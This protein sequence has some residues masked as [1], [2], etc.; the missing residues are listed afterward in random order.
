MPPNTQGIAALVALNIVEGCAL[1]EMGHNSP[2]YLHSLIEAM[3]VAL[4]DVRNHVAD[5]QEDI[6]LEDLLS[7]QRAENLRRQIAATARGYAA[8]I[9]DRDHTDTVYVAV[10]DEQRNAVSMISSIYK[11]F[12]SGITVPGTGLLLQNRGACF[13]LDP[14]HPNRIG[15]GKR[16]LHTIIPAMIL[17]DKKPWAVLGVVGGSMQAQGHLQVICNLIDFGMSPQAALDSPRFRILDDGSLTLEEAI[18]EAAR[19]KLAALGHRINT[20]QTEEGFGG[21][22]VIL[23]SEDALYAGSD[24]R[25][26]GCAI[27]Y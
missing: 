6:P 2:E 23:I 18:P 12:G 10:V 22:Q 27:G 8:A 25:K 26:D 21:G 14:G 1:P 7:K 15:P 11:A 19:S 9:D 5:P 17:R 3:K 20:E 4:T 13:S 24:P 16:P